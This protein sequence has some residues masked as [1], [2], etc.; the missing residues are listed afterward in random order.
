MK[1]HNSI[2]LK[3]KELEKSIA[4]TKG[5]SKKIMVFMEANHLKSYTPPQIHEE[6]FDE[7]VPLT[8][9]RRSLTD[10]T[11]KGHLR[12]TAE[13]REGLYGMSNHCWTFRKSL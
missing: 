10:L 4:R 2:N 5:Q 7:S 9:I 11:A 3:G 8:S 1:F 6:L 13:V 12:Q